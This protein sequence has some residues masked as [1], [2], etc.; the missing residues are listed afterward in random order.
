MFEL[1]K[2]RQAGTVVWHETAVEL[3]E[4]SGYYV[5]MTKISETTIQPY[6]IEYSAR[7]KAFNAN[8]LLLSA[9]YAMRADK[10]IYWAEIDL[11]QI[12]KEEKRSKK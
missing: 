1:E 12:K 11:P 3:P 4:K 10:I 2:G 5:V 9:P 7:H 6:A 8:D